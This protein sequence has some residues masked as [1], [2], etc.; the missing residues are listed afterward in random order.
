MTR[1]TDLNHFFKDYVGGGLIA[2][3][4]IIIFLTLICLMG[5][6]EDAKG[7]RKEHNL[8]AALQ[9]ESTGDSNAQE[10]ANLIKLVLQKQ[11]SLPEY[12][13]SLDKLSSLKNDNSFYLKLFLEKREKIANLVSGKIKNLS[14][15]VE[16]PKWTTF[17]KWFAILSWLCLAICATINF[18]GESLDSSESLLEWPW[19][20]A[21]VYPA[22]LVM[23]PALLPCMAIEITGRLFI[24]AFRSL[25]TRIT[26]AANVVVQ[27]DANDASEKADTTEVKKQEALGQ[28]SNV[29]SRIEA[30]KE[31]WIENCL[32]RLDQ[33]TN[34]LEEKVTSNRNNLSSLGREIA[35]VQRTLAESQKEL[36]NW[37]TGLET[38]KGKAKED[39]LRDFEQLTKL[40]HVSAVEVNGN[41]LY[42]YTDMVYIDNA[43]E[44]YEIGMIMINIDMMSGEFLRLKNLCSTHPHGYDHPYGSGGSFCWGGLSRPISNA[45]RVKEF[46]SAVQFMIQAIYSADGDNP[47]K[48]KEWKEV[49]KWKKEILIS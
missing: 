13:T 35:R 42:V 37:Q 25:R 45:L 46:A 6:Y 4:L 30:T 33:E 19:D 9:G 40:P 7:P 14:R 36:M 29:Q 21:W 22:I 24:I 2:A 47:S 48:V 11:K 10:A 34:R 23:S 12:L 16:V 26:R 1:R 28:I 38:T 8:Y 31:V 41:E 43:F 49:S 27:S 3:M 44:R 20:E 39:Y 15:T 17:W 18:I 5:Y 32:D